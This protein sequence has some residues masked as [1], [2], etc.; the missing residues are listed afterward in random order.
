MDS[1]W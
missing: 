1:Y